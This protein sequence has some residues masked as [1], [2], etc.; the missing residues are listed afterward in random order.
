MFN[1]NRVMDHIPEIIKLRPA[2]LK[3]LHRIEYIM[4]EAGKLHPETYRHPIFFV[5]TLDT[6][7][8]H[9]AFVAVDKKDRTIAFVL[10]D[11][12]PERKMANYIPKNSLKLANTAVSPQYQGKHLE[13][14]LAC[15]GLTHCKYVN[16]SD[17]A[18]C[19]IHP[20]NIASIKSL[21]AAGFCLAYKNVDYGYGI[22]NLYVQKLR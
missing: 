16:T 15:Y 2:K 21:T 17:Y 3:D 7:L 4:H 1:H 20:D 8:Y 10:F 22:R 9:L 12:L 5:N 11:N 13:Y 14:R 18:W 19:A 6:I